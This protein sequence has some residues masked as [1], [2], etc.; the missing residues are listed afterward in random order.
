MKGKKWNTFYKLKNLSGKGKRELGKGNPVWRKEVHENLQFIAVGKREKCVVLKSW[1]PFLSFSLLIVYFLLKAVNFICDH[2]DI[3]AISFVGSNQAGE[4]IFERGSRN[5]KRVQANMVTS[6]S[7]YLQTALYLS[8]LGAAQQKGTCSHPKSLF[9]SC[10]MVV[11]Q[12]SHLSAYIY[13]DDTGHTAVLPENVN[14]VPRLP[15]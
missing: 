15:Q 5:G 7:F 12:E 2:P 3:K 4:Y 11:S 10:E 14:P 6:Y 1:W 13:V 9:F 8:F